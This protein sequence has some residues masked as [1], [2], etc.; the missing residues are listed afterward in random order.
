[1]LFLMSFTTN[2]GDDS[3]L[4]FGSRQAALQWLF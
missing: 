4:R 2:D 1:M 3:L